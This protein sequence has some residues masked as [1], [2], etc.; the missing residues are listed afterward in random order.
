MSRRGPG[1]GTVYRR[2]D[3][4]WEGTLYLGSVAGKRVKRSFYGKTRKEVVQKLDAARRQTEQGLPLAPER[5]TLT[6]YLEQWLEDAARLRVRE[7]TFVG[8]ETIVRRHLIPAIGQLRLTRLGPQHVQAMLAKKIEEGLAPRTVQSIHAVL[9]MALNDALRWELV[10]RNV[11]ALVTPPRS[12]QSDVLTL[13]SEQARRLLDAAERDRLGAL[14]SV[15]LALG[16]RRGEAL[17]LRW[18]DVAFERGTLRVERSLQRVGGA[19]RLTEPK[20]SRSRRTIALPAPAASS[21]RAHRARQ[22]EERLQAGSEW[23]DDDLVFTTQFGTPLDPRNVSRA[24]HK[25]L[26]RTGLPRM[27]FHDLRHTCASLLLAQNVHPRV[28]METL[29]HSR[30]STT[31]DLYSHVAPEVQRDA[32]VGMERALEELA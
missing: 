17:G 6:S 19:L 23:Q 20:T 32:A 31:M 30:I 10:Q 8:Y 28:V 24:F 12:E 4:R 7:R 13:S 22:L 15:A 25:L 14:F 3:G 11:A 1:E 9:R 2:K 21:L 27:R 29:G 5:Q 16:L 18:G 26:A